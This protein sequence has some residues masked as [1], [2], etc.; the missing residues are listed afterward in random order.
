MTVWVF[1]VDGVLCNTN[2]ISEAPF[3]EWF[4]S[5][6]KGRR[7]Y[8][9]TGGMRENTIL[10]M[11]QEIVDG[12]VMTYNCLGNSIWYNG[13]ETLINQF[14]LTEQEEAWLT[15]QLSTSKFPLR[16]G[17]H[18]NM[19]TGSMN[20]CIVGRD[21][22]PEQ[23]LAYRSWDA[24]HQ[25]RASIAQEFVRMFPRFEAYLGGDISIDI[26]LKGANKGAAANAIREFEKDSMIFFGDRCHPG[27]IDEPFVNACNFE[28]GDRVFHV[29]G[30]NETWNILKELK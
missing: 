20:F 18:I 1:D 22:S 9:V 23:R 2:C 10:Q 14:T 5:W 4:L 3:R 30:Y 17:R 8:L 12:A 26:C 29:S 6:S 24:H 21:A 13:Q 7:Y 16:T 28:N 25:E 27:G 11:G 19:R 15:H